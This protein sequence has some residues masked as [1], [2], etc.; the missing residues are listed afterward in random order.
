MARLE[1]MSISCLVFL[2]FPVSRLFVFDFWFVTAY[3]HSIIS[4]NSNKSTVAGA[5]AA[6]LDHEKTPR[7][8]ATYSKATR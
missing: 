2:D 4:T 7:M 6:I 1:L 3:D 5:S 8:K